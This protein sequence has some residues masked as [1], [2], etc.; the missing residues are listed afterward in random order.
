MTQAV[1]DIR[2]ATAWLADR[3]EVDAERL[4]IFGVSLGG[5]TAARSLQPPSRS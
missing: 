4:G 5:I 1:L 3:P 2:R